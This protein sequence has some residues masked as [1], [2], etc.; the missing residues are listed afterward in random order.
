MYSKP[1]NFQFYDNHEKI[2]NL[3]NTCFLCLW[4]W[5]KW[6]K[7]LIR[8][9]KSKKKI[10]KDKLKPF[11]FFNQL[12]LPKMLLKFHF[13]W[14]KIDYLEHWERDPKI[15]AKTCAKTGAEINRYEWRPSGFMKKMNEGFYRVTHFVHSK[16]MRVSIGS[17]ASLAT[18]NRNTDVK[19]KK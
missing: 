8:K 18:K 19:S 5:E 13:N 15:G 6:K 9:K 7:S 12:Y 11:N 10:N 4:L 3:S 17:L 2:S 16:W 14:T 1:Y